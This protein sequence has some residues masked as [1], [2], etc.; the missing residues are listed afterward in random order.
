M[1]VPVIVL[2]LTPVPPL[3][4]GIRNFNL[5]GEDGVVWTA[6]IWFDSETCGWLL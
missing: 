2:G 6:L 3:M 4:T 1:W 5:E